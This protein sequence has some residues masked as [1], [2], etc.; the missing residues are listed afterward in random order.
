MCLLPSLNDK[1]MYGFLTE[2]F[3]LKEM[4]ML[5]VFLEK[6][7]SSN[8]YYSITSLSLMFRGR[9]RDAPLISEKNKMPSV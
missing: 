3:L 1:K 9:G 4:K 8:G 5:D 6:E 7:N 2:K